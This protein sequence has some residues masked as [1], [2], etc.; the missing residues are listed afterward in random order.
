MPDWDEVQHWCYDG[1]A[2]CFLRNSTI[3]SNANIYNRNPK[4]AK[5]VKEVKYNANSATCF[6]NEDVLHLYKGPELSTAFQL[7][8]AATDRLCR[9]VKSATRHLVSVEELCIAGGNPE[10]AN[11]L[12]GVLRWSP[13]LNRLY[14]QHLN[15]KHLDVIRGHIQRNPKGKGFKEDAQED[16][17]RTIHPCI[18]VVEIINVHYGG[19]AK[20]YPP[21]V[22]SQRPPSWIKFAYKGAQR[23]VK[24]LDQFPN[25]KHLEMDGCNIPLEPVLNSTI[26]QRGKVYFPKRPVIKAPAPGDPLPIAANDSYIPDYSR[27]RSEYYEPFRER[28]PPGTKVRKLNLSKLTHVE[29]NRRWVCYTNHKDMK[30][31]PGDWLSSPGWEEFFL[32]Q[33]SLKTVGFHGGIL[34]RHK[35]LDDFAFKRVATHL[36]RT[37]KR[38]AIMHDTTFKPAGS[39]HF[40]TDVPHLPHG[41]EFNL[42]RF[43]NLLKYLPHLEELELAVIHP[44]MKLRHAVRIA[45]ALKGNKMKTFHLHRV[46][47]VLTLEQTQKLVEYLPNIESLYLISQV[48]YLLNAYPNVLEDEKVTTV[49]PGQPAT[50]TI[51][52]QFNDPNP[53][54]APL[55]GPPAGVELAGTQYT[56]PLEPKDSP[57]SSDE[58]SGGNPEPSHDALQSFDFDVLL[59]TLSPLKKL[60][61]LIIPYIY[62]APIELAH[63]DMQSLSLHLNRRVKITKYDDQDIRNANKWSRKVKREY[64]RAIER[65]GRGFCSKE[66]HSF[67][68]V[69]TDTRNESM[70]TEETDLGKKENHNGSSTDAE[71]V[72]YFSANIPH[73]P[74]SHTSSLPASESKH[75]AKLP[76]LPKTRIW[77]NLRNVDIRYFCPEECFSIRLL[78]GGRGWFCYDRWSEG[79]RTW[80]EEVVEKGGSINAGEIL[81]NEKVDECELEVRYQDVKFW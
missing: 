9:L 8:R 37:L 38:L 17:P 57:G 15:I 51:I 79:V 13:R 10:I 75:A 31:V 53:I 3:E 65:V 46:N 29:F 43:I 30:V 47:D 72:S 5:H 70:Q 27:S 63:L 80:A 7:R 16:N 6:P 76:S 14:L 26:D 22:A 40:Y 2:V 44:G 77:P 19:A 68:D 73:D 61:N 42:P 69:K 54:L 58:P 23:L 81:G 25:I 33:H 35:L 71:E 34:S 50:I 32:S 59:R 21:G 20:R 67:A 18:E 1:F 74:S 11:A 4:L 64:L 24:L 55:Q 48:P 45:E 56:Y 41:R 78:S 49:L 39:R 36:G 28:Y 12:M 62:P 66:F 60:E 52:N